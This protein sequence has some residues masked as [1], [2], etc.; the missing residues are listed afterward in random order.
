MS[1][2]SGRISNH[3]TFLHENTALPGTKCITIY[4]K[5]LHDVWLCQ[6]RRGGQQLLQGLEC[7]IMFHI[8]NKLFTFLQ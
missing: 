6:H 2:L 7:F 1:E 8:P 3:P 5:G 4:V